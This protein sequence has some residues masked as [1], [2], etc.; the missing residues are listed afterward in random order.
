MKPIDVATGLRTVIEKLEI[1]KF[2]YMIVGSVAG[3]VYGEPR[4]YKQLFLLT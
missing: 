3:A 4:P 1:A 2:D